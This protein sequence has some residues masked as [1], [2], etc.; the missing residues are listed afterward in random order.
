MTY[1]CQPN[2]HSNLQVNVLVFLP[3]L[4]GQTCLVAIAPDL[5][6]IGEASLDRIA[7]GRISV[8]QIEPIAVAFMRELI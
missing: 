6:Q 4:T 7:V 8:V 5:V 1:G 3:A 2:T